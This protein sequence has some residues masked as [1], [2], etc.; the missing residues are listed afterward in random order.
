MSI[1]VITPQ[2][3][4]AFKKA[5]ILHFV[6]ELPDFENAQELVDLW[7]SIETSEEFFAN[8]TP[9][10]PFEFFDYSQ[11]QEMVSDLADSMERV[12]FEVLGLA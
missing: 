11:I 8:F 1:H 9:W 7:E 5:A 4:A 2:Q 3:A 10:Q 12:H 6:S